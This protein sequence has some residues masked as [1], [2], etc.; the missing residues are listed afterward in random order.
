V[1]TKTLKD[2]IH[3][4]LLETKTKTRISVDLYLGETV[5]LLFLNLDKCLLAAFC[6][7][8]LSIT[9]KAFYHQSE[10]LSSV[11]VIDNGYM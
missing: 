2:R 6:F 11:R 3:K 1:F 5:F 4:E 8:L 9:F 10:Y 7:S